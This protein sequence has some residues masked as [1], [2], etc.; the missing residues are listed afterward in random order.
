MSRDFIFLLFINLFSIYLCSLENNINYVKNLYGE[1]KEIT[2]DY[3]K[4]LS[5]ICN[6]GI[7]VGKKMETSSLLKEYLMLNHQLRT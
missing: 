1:N 6:N 7:F 2:G 3:D 4:D 5:A